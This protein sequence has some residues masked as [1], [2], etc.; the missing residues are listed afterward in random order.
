MCESCTPP[1]IS[2]RPILFEESRFA[3]REQ[4]QP[5]GQKT[6]KSENGTG[7][8]KIFG[9]MIRPVAALVG[10]PAGL[11]NTEVTTFTDL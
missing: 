6:H 9:A 4:W 7:E 11:T 2:I 3:R 10:P 1:P 5:L 8:G